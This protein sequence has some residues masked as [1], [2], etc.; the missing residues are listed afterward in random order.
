MI[1]FGLIDRRERWV[2]K[3]RGWLV[4]IISIATIFFLILTTIHP[5]LSVNDPAEGDILVVEGMDN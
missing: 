1:K 2:L 5:F 4:L 3:G